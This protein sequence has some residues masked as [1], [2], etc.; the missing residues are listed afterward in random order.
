MPTGLVAT[1]IVIWHLQGAPPGCR[2]RF[3]VVY[4]LSLDASPNDVSQVSG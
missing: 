3:E 2:E 1:Q 4:N